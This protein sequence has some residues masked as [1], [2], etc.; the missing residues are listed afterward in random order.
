MTLKGAKRSQVPLF[1]REI[2]KKAQEKG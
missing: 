1:Q 2:G